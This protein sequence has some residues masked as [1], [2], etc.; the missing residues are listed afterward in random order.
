MLYGLS[1]IFLALVSGELLRQL[2]QL[3]IPAVVIGMLLL[4]AWC[5]VRRGAEPR[6]VYA[7]EGLLR[8]LGILF[9]P[10]GVGLIEL[11]DKLKSQGVAMVVTILMST[12]ITLLVTGLVLQFLLARRKAKLTKQATK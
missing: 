2:F 5:I 3:P 9:V 11:G 8:Y 10:A 4:T 7:S 1:I 12:V 6:V